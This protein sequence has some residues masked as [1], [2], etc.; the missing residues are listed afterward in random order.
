[1]HAEGW[2]DPTA[3][4]PRTGLL[5]IAFGALLLAF[6]VFMIAAVGEALLAKFG[7]AKVSKVR[8]PSDNPFMPGSDAIP[9]VWAGRTRDLADYSDVVRARRTAGVYERGRAVLGEPGIGKSVLVAKVRQTAAEMGDIVLPAVRL[10][11][12]ADP[13]T[14][15]AAAVEEAVQTHSLV[16]RLARHAGDMLDRVRSISAA[17]SVTLDE[18]APNSPHVV[19]TQAI[20][21]LARLAKEDGAALV[22]H[23]DEIQNVT[24]RNLLSGLLVALGDSLNAVTTDSDAAGSPHTRHLPVVVY[25]TGLWNFADEATRAAGATFAR[26]FKP[27]RLG[28]LDDADIQIALSPFTTTGWPVLTADGP[29]QVTMTE[30]AV[31]ALIATVLGDPFL[32][33]LLGSATWDAAPGEAVIT[34]AHVAA[35]VRDVGHEMETHVRRAVERLPARERELLEALVALDPGE[36]TLTRAGQ[37]LGRTASEVGSY[38]ARLE[39]RS[40]IRRDRPVVV[41]ARPV[42]ALLTGSWPRPV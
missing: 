23:L 9:L 17:V 1:M 8:F 6:A 29:A 12:G 22:I 4:G 42:E 11:R 19:L 38:S 13:I 41:T 36:R 34:A 18:P 37:A 14:L 10:P 16:E 25:L 32:L 21:T 27:V 26:R 24:D 2:D 5:L 20:T 7:D 3:K 33:Q 28:W 31:H 30:A 39:M 35:G 40:L 15:L